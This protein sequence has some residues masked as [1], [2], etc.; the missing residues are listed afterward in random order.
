MEK[1]GV[2]RIKEVSNHHIIRAVVSEHLMAAA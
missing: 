2:V 1:N